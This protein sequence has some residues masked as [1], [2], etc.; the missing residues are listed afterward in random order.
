MY[1]FFQVLSFVRSDRAL[2][3]IATKRLVRDAPAKMFGG[4]QSNRCWSDH[5][6]NRDYVHPSRILNLKK[7]PSAIDA[8][9]K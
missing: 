5:Q 9:V 4:F 3:A 6:N 2:E 8:V 7:K 1:N